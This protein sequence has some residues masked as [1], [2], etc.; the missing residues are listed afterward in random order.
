MKPRVQAYHRRFFA[1]NIRKTNLPS[2]KAVRHNVTC[3]TYFPKY[4]GYVDISI[5]LLQRVG[6]YDTIPICRWC[7]ISGCAG[8][9]YTRSRI[10][11]LRVL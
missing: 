9:S 10:T 7:R 5:F 2:D 6:K 3:T 4:A 8:C 1:D 11:V